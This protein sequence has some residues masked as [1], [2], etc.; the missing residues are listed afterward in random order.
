MAE[1]DPILEYVDV[2]YGHVV[3]EQT[4]VIGKALREELAKG[5]GIELIALDADRL[6]VI[7][8]VL[9]K[10]PRPLLSKRR[11]IVPF[12]DG[13]KRTPCLSFAQ[14]RLGAGGEDASNRE[15]AR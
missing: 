7:G 9:Q 14:S 15:R 3:L 6:E 12:V 11:P 8:D 10:Q 4:H 1:T 5:R 2:L 13:V